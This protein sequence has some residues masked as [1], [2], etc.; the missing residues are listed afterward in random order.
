MFVTVMVTQCVFSAASTKQYLDEYISDG[1]PD[2]LNTFLSSKVT[3]Y[4]CTTEV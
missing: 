3:G 4:S 2:D 1:F